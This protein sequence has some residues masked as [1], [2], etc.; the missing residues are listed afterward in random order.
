MLTREKKDLNKQAGLN[1]N[2]ENKTAIKKGTY[3]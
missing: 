3:C 1:M 2:R